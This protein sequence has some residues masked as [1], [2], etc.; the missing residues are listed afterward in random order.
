MQPNC[1]RLSQNSFNKRLTKGFAI[2]HALEEWQMCCI[3]S[4]SKNPRRIMNGA[5]FTLFD[6]NIPGVSHALWCALNT[7]GFYCVRI[8]YWSLEYSRVF[9]LSQSER[10]SRSKDFSHRLLNNIIQE[11]GS[12]HN[13]Q[14]SLLMIS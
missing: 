12:D 9:W 3:T 8:T 6:T 13:C 14:Y 7:L 5:Y 4:T 11:T 10:S 1:Y 2:H